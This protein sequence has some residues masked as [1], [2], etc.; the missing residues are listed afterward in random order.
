MI[1]TRILMHCGGITLIQCECGSWFKSKRALAAHQAKCPV[2]LRIKEEE[3]AKETYY[4]EL[5]QIATESKVI[6]DKYFKENQVLIQ[7]NKELKTELKRFDEYKEAFL[8]LKARREY[9]EEENFS[10]QNQLNE[11][12]VLCSGS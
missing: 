5:E 2:V 11:L 7:E 9:L 3:R 1:M 12:A 4:A 8:I 10:L 6:A